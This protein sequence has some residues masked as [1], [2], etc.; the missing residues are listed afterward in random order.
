MLD[1]GKTSNCMV[2]HISGDKTRYRMNS[3][4]HIPFHFQ[5]LACFDHAGSTGPFKRRAVSVGN[6]QRRNCGYAEYRLV[7]DEQ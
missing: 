5:G 3:S 2:Q 7:F 6:Y 4:M 1:V